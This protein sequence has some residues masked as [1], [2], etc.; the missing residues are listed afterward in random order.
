MPAK[1]LAF[2]LL[3][4]ALGGRAEAAPPRPPITGVSHIAVYSADMAKSERFYVHDLGGV[5]MPDPEDAKGVRYYF[6]P[7]QFV[8]VLPLP[9]NAGKN[10]LEHVAFRTADAE[11]L[12]RYMAAKGIAVPARTAKA[13]DGSRYFRVSDPEGNR[14]EFVQPPENPPQIAPNPL[15]SH[16]IHVGYIVH[17]RA[18]ED[19][20]YRDV[21]G[22]RPYWY[23]GSD[24]HP[25]AW[26]SQQV[27]DGTDW[28]EY[29]VQPG[30]RGIP[31]AM[32]Q[33]TAGVLN[34]FSFGVANIRDAVTLL[35]RGGRL[36]AKSDGPK[37]GRDG[38]WQF[39][40]Y[41]PDGTRAEIMEFHA[42][43]EPCC[44]S[45]TAGDPEE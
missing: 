45:F 13:K 14:V 43:A 23:G 7:V 22:F 11:A 12:R 41:D 30:T 4:M 31:E 35:Y 44:S 28:L 38:K 39:N 26:V 21:L 24:E 29:M 6:S 15:S 36:T 2:F 20:F 9:A 1:R 3:A 27:P 8:A 40:L 17:D 37:I 10:R 18:G 33:A 42:V 25:A 19:A 5:K 34:H 32:P 16:I